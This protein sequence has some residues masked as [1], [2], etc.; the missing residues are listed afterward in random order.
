MVGGT[1][2]D[3]VD[4]LDVA[5]IVV[6]KALLVEDNL[7]VDEAAGQGV[8]DGG[9]LFVDFLHHEGVEAVLL[10]G[11]LVPV[12]GE[13]A[14]LGRGAV[15][16]HDL[17]VIGGDRD[18]AVLAELDGVLGVGDEGGDVRTKEH[19]VLPDPDDQRGVAA[20]GDD[21]IRLVGVGEQDGEGTFQATQDGERG[22][23]DVPGELALVVL[24]GEQVGGDLGVRVRD[25]FDAAGLELVAQGGEVL[26]DAVVDDGGLAVEGEVRVR[27]DVVR[28]TVG[29]PT[30]VA[31]TGVAGQGVATNDVDALDEVAELAFCFF[32]ADTLCV[33]DGDTGGIVSAVLHPLQCIEPDFQGLLLSYVSN[34]CAHKWKRYTPA[35]PMRKQF[36]LV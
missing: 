3:D 28:A 15:E 36:L 29:G 31:Q 16:V 19:A 32:Y 11:L 4:L 24:D 14:A 13:R 5:Q 33:I 23:L 22:G 30:G 21:E 2:G 27:V 12:D 8:A 25:E 1:A 20:T 18:G 7:A 34:D 17:V 10:G 6:G 26:D 9:G 35:W